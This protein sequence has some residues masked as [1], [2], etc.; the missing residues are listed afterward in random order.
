MPEVFGTKGETTTQFD[1]LM[2]GVCAT[3]FNAR[4]RTTEGD[5]AVDIQF[6]AATRDDGIDITRSELIDAVG[7]DQHFAAVDGRAVAVAVGVAETDRRA[8]RERIVEA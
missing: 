7:R 3:V 1:G 6:A 8:E 2:G 5:A 4:T